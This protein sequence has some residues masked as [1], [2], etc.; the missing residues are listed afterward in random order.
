MGKAE[1]KVEIDE[2]LLEQARAAELHV[3]LLVE[4]ALKTALGS[5]AAEERA[6]RWAEE[7]ADAIASHNRFVE[8]NG[9][10]GREWRSW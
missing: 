7:N 4:R 3:N 8:E 5:T 6:R 1:L 9:E 2:H 10:F